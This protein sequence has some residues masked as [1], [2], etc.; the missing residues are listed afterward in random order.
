[1]FTFNVA[2]CNKI[3]DELLKSDK[4]KLSHP[5]PLIDE[6]KGVLIVNGITPLLMPLMIAISSVG[7][8]NR[9]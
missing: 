5:I 7:K 9:L 8:Y 2:K 6:F 1:M 4:I 3:F